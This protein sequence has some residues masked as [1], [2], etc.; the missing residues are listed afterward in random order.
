MFEGVGKLRMIVSFFSWFYAICRYQ[1]TGDF[2]FI[3]CKQELI[4]VEDNSIPGTV[5]DAVHCGPESR[6]NGFVPEKSIVDATSLSGHIHRGVVESVGV[7]V[8]RRVKTL[9]CT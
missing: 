7:S 5:G 1:E 2:N 6:F 3:S 4:R 8:S 9:R